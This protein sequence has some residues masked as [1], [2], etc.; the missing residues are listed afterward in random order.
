M[1]QVR[2]YKKKKEKEIGE[3]T[4]QET[5]EGEEA[6]GRKSENAQR[7]GKKVEVVEYLF[8]LIA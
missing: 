1:S 7:V 8:L 6:C 5:G 3:E 2:D 4:G